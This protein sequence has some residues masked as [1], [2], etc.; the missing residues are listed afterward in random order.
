MRFGEEKV[1][2]GCVEGNGGDVPGRSFRHAG[3][4]SEN[5]NCFSKKS[6]VRQKCRA[7][8]IFPRDG[9]IFSAKEVEEKSGDRL[10]LGEFQWEDF[11]GNGAAFRGKNG[12]EMATFLKLWSR[13]KG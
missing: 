10:E 6:A 13:G 4:D 1:I 9:S 2:V 5:P 7:A 11:S 12:A 8:W 3:K